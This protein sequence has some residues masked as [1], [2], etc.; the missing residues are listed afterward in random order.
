VGKFD[1]SI[2]CL[3]VKNRCF[4]SVRPVIVGVVVILSTYTWLVPVLVRYS[5]RQVC[6]AVILT[7]ECNVDILKTSVVR[8]S[9]GD[10]AFKCV[11]RRI[12]RDEPVTMAIAV[13][14]IDHDCRLAVMRDV[15]NLVAN[16]VTQRLHPVWWCKH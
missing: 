6:D 14:D 10:C 8:R 2:G 16:L 3:R 7:S 12:A 4:A 1:W 5:N 9:D 15:A 13:V 11:H